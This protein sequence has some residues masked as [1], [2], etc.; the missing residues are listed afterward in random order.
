MNIVLAL[1]FFGGTK[2]IQYRVVIYCNGKE[3]QKEKVKKK[4]KHSLGVID[5]SSFTMLEFFEPI[6]IL[7]SRLLVCLC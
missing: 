3:K 4:K 2:F 5:L 7:T 1:S 6:A